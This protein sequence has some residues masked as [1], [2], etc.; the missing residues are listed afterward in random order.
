MH[1]YAESNT[2]YES[3]NFENCW[4]FGKKLNLQLGTFVEYLLLCFNEFEII[5]KACHMTFL[6]Q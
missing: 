2:N 6:K 4:P 5:Y 3:L 1:F